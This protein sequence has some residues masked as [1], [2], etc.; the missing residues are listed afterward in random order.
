MAS[1]YLTV[2]EFSELIGHSESTVW[3]YIRDQKIPKF[4]PGGPGHRVT[5]PAD[6]AIGLTP[7]NPPPAVPS[8]P[9]DESTE[10]LHLSGP[11]PKWL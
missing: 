8:T 10:P 5:I 4:Q 3:R 11:K 6:A 9:V 7:P 1:Q 2:K